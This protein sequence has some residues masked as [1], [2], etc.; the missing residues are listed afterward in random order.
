MPR[1]ILVRHAK[2][3]WNDPARADHDRPLNARGRHAAP[4]IGRWLAAQG[5]VPDEVLTSPAA[6]TRETWALMAPELPG[7][8]PVRTVPALYLAAPATMLQ[9]LRG[10][11]GATVLM[12]GHNPGIAEFAALLAA[13]PPEDP[14]FRRYPTGA[15]TLFD[16]GETPWPAVTGRSGRVAGFT[17]PRRLGD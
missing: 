13:D 12:L 2:S 17:V 9:T 16:L 4:R 7:P 3:S 6:R 15:A 8:V 14:E 1:L 10:A 5:A 11:T